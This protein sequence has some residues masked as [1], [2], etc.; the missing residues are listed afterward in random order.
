MNTLNIIFK[1]GIVYRSLILIAGLIGYTYAQKNSTQ[2]YTDFVN[3]FIGTDFRGN[4]FPGATVPFGMVQLSPDTYVTGDRASG[5]RYNAK[6][7]IGFS[8]THLSGTG[9]GEMLDLLI[10]PMTGDLK[11]EPGREAIPDSGF[12]SRFTHEDEKATPGYYAVIL[13]DYGIKTELTA[14][15]R[16]GMHRYTFPESKRVHIVLDLEHRFFNPDIP[17]EILE[18][19]IHIV[20]DSL[21][22]GRRR[23]MGLA[24][25]RYFYFAAKFSK[26]FLSYGIYNDKKISQKI[27]NV[28]GRN[29]KCY[30]TYL[31]QVGEQIQIKVGISAV[32]IE[33]ALKNLNHEVPHWNFDQVKMDAEEKWNQELGKIG[34]E[35]VLD[36][37]KTTFYTALYHTMLAPVHYSDVEGSYRGSDFLIHKDDNFQNY[38]IFPLWETFRAL[39]PLFTISQQQRVN[40]FVQSMIA[41]SKE[42]GSLPVWHLAANETNSKSGTLSIPVIIDAY[43]KGLAT[44]DAKEVY[45]LIKKNELRSMNMKPFQR[46][47][48]KI[49]D[50]V[51][52]TVS[53]S[54]YREKGY[55]PYDISNHSVSKT[56]EYA[57]TD[58]C[59]AQLAK[60]LGY[61]ADYRKFMQSAKFY[62]NVYDSKKGWMRGKSSSGVWREPFN[63][64]KIINHWQEGDYSGASAAQNSWF[65]PHDIEGLINLMGG[66]K[67]FTEKLN[68]FFNPKNQSRELAEDVAGFV[69]LY[70]QGNEP[71]HHTA[72]LFN[73]VGQPEKTQAIVRW[74]LTRLYTN[75]PVGL[76]GNDDCG[77]LSAWYIFSALGFYPVNPCGGIYLFGAPW[78]KEAK[79]NLP[80][81]KKFQILTEN[82]SMDN[83]YIQTVTLNG[84]TYTKLWITHT[85]IMQGGTIVFKMGS[86]PNKEWG[87]GDL[88]IPVMDMENDKIY[89]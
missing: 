72:Y 4:T 28:S 43:L 55:V 8:H 74:I 57:Y 21:I 81:G 87:A 60:S 39:H 50:R 11:L 5:Y 3:P 22:T 67:Q 32:S 54:L 82:Q 35:F 84:K 10:M 7:I 59:I 51:D 18:A 27:R 65:V 56:L 63:P 1:S 24:T 73:Y 86:E 33:G 83:K 40:D 12:R 34:A 42:T 79:I 14:T 80:D 89:K 19:E 38:H 76:T 52:P 44:F 26:S 37:A 70:A 48:L 62:K 69:G 53:K 2:D 23:I 61:G 9:Q 30:V 41:I 49:L 25:N 64:Y 75:S 68:F 31:T 16:V 17:S 45:A 36:N 46:S 58:W 6:S 20:N 85:E 15:D 66:K 88:E 78:V 13:K 71:D 77:Q 29:L 47:D